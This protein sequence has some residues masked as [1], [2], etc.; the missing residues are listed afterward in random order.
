MDEEN[1]QR[2]NMQGGDRAWNCAMRSASVFASRDMKSIW[3]YMKASIL[4][5]WE[6]G[7]YTILHADSNWLPMLHHFTEL[8]KGCCHI[9]LDS[10]TD[11]FT[12]YE[13]LQGHQSIRRVL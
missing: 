7:I 6:A 2:V 11:I 8:S 4:R 9:E 5:F 1:I 13:I 3:P 12:A 10:A